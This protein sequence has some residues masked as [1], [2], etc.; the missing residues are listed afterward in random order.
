M[1]VWKF[2]NSSVLLCNYLSVFNIFKNYTDNVL[3]ISGYLLFKENFVKV[4][5][6]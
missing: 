5:L 1:W 4:K 2:D 3:N 6:F